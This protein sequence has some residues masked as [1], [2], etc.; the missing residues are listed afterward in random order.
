MFLFSF[1]SAKMLKSYSNSRKSSPN[2]TPVKKQTKVQSLLD[3]SRL[4]PPPPNTI[5]PGGN[6]LSTNT[7][8]NYGLGVGMQDDTDLSQSPPVQEQQLRPRQTI[9]LH[10]DENEILSIPP[11]SNVIWLICGWSDDWWFNT[12]VYSTYTIHIIIYIACHQPKDWITALYE[13]CL[14][15]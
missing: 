2:R 6:L 8:I 1:C 15:E 5:C 12:Y 10:L 7:R 9:S 3:P 4:R 13:I 11:D 14:I